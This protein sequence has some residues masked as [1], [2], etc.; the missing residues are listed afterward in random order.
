MAE[1]PFNVQ[2]SDFFPVEEAV[3]VAEADFVSSFPP[4]WTAW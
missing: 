4:K 3:E 1:D 2:P